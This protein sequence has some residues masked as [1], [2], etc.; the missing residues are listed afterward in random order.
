MLGS[1]IKDPD[2]VR[3]VT[4]DFTDFLGSKTIS[5]ATWTIPAG[6]TKKSESNTTTAAS[7]ILSGGTLN[8][9]YKCVCRI[10][11]GSSSPAEQTDRTILVLIK[12]K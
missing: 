2:G 3:E 9:G 6:I 10:T 4:I 5:A 12:Q 1:F 7:V 11:F 8:V